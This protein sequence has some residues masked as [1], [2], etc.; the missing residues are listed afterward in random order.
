MY[1]M[2]VVFKKK[3]HASSSRLEIYS[4]IKPPLGDSA[5]HQG[6]CYS[7]TEQKLLHP[8]PSKSQS[9]MVL[10]SLKPSRLALKL[11]SFHPSSLSS[12][13]FQFSQSVQSHPL[14]QDVFKWHQAD[15][16]HKNLTKNSTP[17]S[18]TPWN[19]VEPTFFTAKSCQPSAKKQKKADTCLAKILLFTWSLFS[20]HYHFQLFFS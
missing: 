10:K 4:A 12:I 1:Q 2:A 11:K 17:R 16:L 13:T 14:Y 9:Y 18:R 15:Q 6:R 5:V 8:H 3:K 7:L 20:I 19:F